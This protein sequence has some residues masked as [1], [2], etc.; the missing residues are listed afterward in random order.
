MNPV[1][2]RPVESKDFEQI[3]NLVNDVVREMYGHLFPNGV[4]ASTDPRSWKSSWVAV[5]G[6]IIAGVGLADGDCID[7]LWLRP[8]YRGRK[9]GSELLSILES[10][11][12]KGGH[13]QAR[14]HV[15]A[16]NETARSF[17][18]RH[19]WQELK[20]YPHEKWEFL[21]MDLRKDLN[22]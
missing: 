14:L 13:V 2:I 10:Q 5:D 3:L 17:Y 7:D 16:E 19:G 15:I 1:I 8:E 11:I 4:T 12:A 18:R 22:C 6:S 20:S 9:I 21:M